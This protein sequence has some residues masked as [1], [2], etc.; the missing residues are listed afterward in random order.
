[1]RLKRTVYRL[2][3]EP[4]EYLVEKATPGR[5]VLSVRVYMPAD[6]EERVMIRARTEIPASARRSDSDSWTF[7]ESRFEVQRRDGQLV[8]VLASDASPLRAG[9]RFSIVLGSDLEVGDYR[10]SL[11]RE[12]GPVCFVYMAMMVL[13]TGDER[14]VFLERDRPVG[15]GSR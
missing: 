3:K 12:A 1:M 13:R 5:E 8:P 10:I 6:A 7:E 2:D 4:L 14:R 15:E 9:Y 11:R